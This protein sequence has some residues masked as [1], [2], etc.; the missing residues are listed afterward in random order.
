MNILIQDADESLLPQI[1]QIEQQSFSVPW[2]ETMLRMQLDKNSHIF[3]TARMDGE[4][5]GYGGLMYVLDEGY[6]SNIAVAAPW[7][8]CGIADTLLRELIARS[9]A[10]FLSFLTLEVRVGN[11]AAIALYEKHGFRTVGRRKDYYE[12]PREDA[13]LMTLRLD[14]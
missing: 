11:A 10:I 9:R 12:R 7:R 2:T 4:T 8:R 5:V 6:I 14:E 13:L 1:Q 3:L